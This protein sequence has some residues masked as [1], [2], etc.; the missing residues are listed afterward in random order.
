MFY[1]SLINFSQFP[2]PTAWSKPLLSVSHMVWYLVSL[3]SVFPPTTHCSEN[4]LSDQCFFKKGKKISSLSS[5]KLF[6]CCRIKSWLTRLCMI[7]SLPI[8][9]LQPILCCHSSLLALPPICQV[10]SHCRAFIPT[11]FPFLLE[12]SFSQ[13]STCLASYSYISALH[14]N[15]STQ[16]S[17]TS[18]STSLWFILSQCWFCVCIF[19]FPSTVEVPLKQG[20]H[21]FCS[22]Y[23]PN[24][25]HQLG[26]QHIHVE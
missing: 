7:R 8:F 3:L 20:P 6:D 19:C 4:S 11:A 2:E 5:L 21:L 16:P 1:L 10:P 14:R 22:H 24:I 17:A 25:W 12:W 15:P 9:P 13:H 26:V 23:I 18:S